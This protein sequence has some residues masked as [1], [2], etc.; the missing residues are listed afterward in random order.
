MCICFVN[1]NQYLKEI[2]LF[3][4]AIVIL[5]TNKFV[6]DMDHLF[7]SMCHIIG[8][9]SSIQWHDHAFLAIL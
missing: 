4:G 5:F 7:M 6:L 8:S 2:S 3:E 9:S 1:D